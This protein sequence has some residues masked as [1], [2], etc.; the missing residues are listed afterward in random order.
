MRRTKKLYKLKRKKKNLKRKT[1]KVIDIDFPLKKQIIHVD[2]V[3]N[4]NYL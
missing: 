1:V 3:I 4:P 2:P